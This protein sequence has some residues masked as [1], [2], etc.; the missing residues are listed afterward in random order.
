MAS[1]KIITE[2][3]TLGPLGTTVTETEILAASCTVEQLIQH[4]VIE[5]TT[6]PTTKEKD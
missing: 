2:N 4:D 3:S 5:N 6:K 1:Y